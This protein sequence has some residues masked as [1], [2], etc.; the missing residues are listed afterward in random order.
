MNDV[1]F[2]RYN[3]VPPRFLFFQVDQTIVAATSIAFGAVTKTL[4]VSMI[5][6]IVLAWLVGRWR[7]SRPDGYLAHMLIW[8][9]VLPAKGRSA[10]N[11][12]IRMIYPT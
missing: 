8:Y 2:P 12:F 1:E 7:E 9:G 11:P 10:I 4:L 5:V 3:D 6:G